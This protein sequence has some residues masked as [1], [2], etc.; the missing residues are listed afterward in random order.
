MVL[1]DSCLD[2]VFD[3]PGAV[4]E[5]Q[6]VVVIDDDGDIAD[7]PQVGDGLRVHRVLSSHDRAGLRRRRPV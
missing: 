1:H 7:V 6:P 3:V 4:D 5:A 2:G